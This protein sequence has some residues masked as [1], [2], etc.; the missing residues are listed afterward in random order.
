MVLLAFNQDV[1]TSVAPGAITFHSPDGAAAEAG[2]FLLKRQARTVLAAVCLICDEGEVVRLFLFNELSMR[3]PMA[4]LEG[5]L[6]NVK[7]DKEENRIDSSIV[8]IM[9]ARKTLDHQQLPGAAVVLQ[10]SHQDYP[11]RYRGASTSS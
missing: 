8:R 6:L 1:T 5:L 3:I 4:S 9:K 10:A 11:A 7:R 2:I